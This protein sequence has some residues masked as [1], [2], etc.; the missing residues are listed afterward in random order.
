MCGLEVALLYLLKSLET[1][2]TYHFSHPTGHQAR[3][4]AESAAEARAKLKTC[5]KKICI[6][7]GA[8][9]SQSAQIHN[10]WELHRASRRTVKRP[11]QQL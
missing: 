9:F 11:L 4:K 7:R 5:I 10:L 3:I 1:M 2:R 6:A 8:A